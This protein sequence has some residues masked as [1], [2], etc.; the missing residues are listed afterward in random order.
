MIHASMHNACAKFLWE[1]LHKDAIE[2]SL[3]AG[4]VTHYSYFKRLKM[5]NEWNIMIVVNHVN[6]LHSLDTHY[7]GPKM[8]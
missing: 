5:T 3:K 1:T 7:M 4:H 2:S 8:T 6:E